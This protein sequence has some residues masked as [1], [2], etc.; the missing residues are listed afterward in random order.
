MPLQT[1]ALVMTALG[2]LGDVPPNSIQ[3]TLVD[4]IH[5]R[6]SFRTDVGFPWY[7]FFLFRRAHRPSRPVC[8]GQILPKIPSG[9]WPSAV[10]NTP[11]GQVSSDRP[12][13]FTD[14]FP[15]GGVAEFDLRAR[16][17]VRLLST[18]RS[19]RT[20]PR[21]ASAFACG[22]ASEPASTSGR[23]RVSSDRIL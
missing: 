16:A 20:A 5:L 15:A 8:F 21:H 9:P 18:P 22:K 23:V 17:Y 4:G 6:W 3:P 14:D 2:V 19:R 13:V 12:L 11:F 7:G 10:L 1:D